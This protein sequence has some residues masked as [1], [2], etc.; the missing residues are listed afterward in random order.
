MITFNLERK[1]NSYCWLSANGK[2]ALGYHQSVGQ[3]VTK[4]A[5][6]SPTLDRNLRQSAR[7]MAGAEA[8]YNTLAS[9][10]NKLNAS[11]ELRKEIEEVLVA[12]DNIEVPS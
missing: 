2:G 11:S 8:M 10:A 7:Q 9:I 6:P 3:I 4:M 12:V 5:N 1:D